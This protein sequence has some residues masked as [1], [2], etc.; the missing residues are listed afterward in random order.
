MGR[1]NESARARYWA[2][3]N[4]VRGGARAGAGA[5]PAGCARTPNWVAGAQQPAPSLA[6]CR[7]RLRVRQRAG[8]LWRANLSTKRPACLRVGLPFATLILI[9]DDCGVSCCG[10]IAAADEVRPTRETGA[11]EVVSL[12]GCLG[13]S[14]LEEEKERRER[15]R[16]ASSSKS[17]DGSARGEPTQQ[18]RAGREEAR[19]N[20]NRG[21]QGAGPEGGEHRGAKE[22]GRHRRPPDQHRAPLPALLDRP[23]ERP[24][25]GPG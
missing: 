10:N 18:V 17:R 22:G 3:R 7:A 5:W 8:H 11:L 6:T 25:A 9:Y 21:R 4:R 23:Q 1:P 13:V 20:R 2:A 24:Q 12:A 15:E 16:D 19:R 14:L